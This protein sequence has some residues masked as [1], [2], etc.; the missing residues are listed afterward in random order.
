V[1]EQKALDA[2]GGSL[3][4]QT[5][6]LK[7]AGAILGRLPPLFCSQ[8]LRERARAVQHTQAEKIQREPI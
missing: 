3:I 5:K 6:L 8:E 4:A 1:L 2:P 7:I